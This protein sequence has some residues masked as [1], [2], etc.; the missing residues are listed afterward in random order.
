MV[1]F[2]SI[3]HSLSFYWQKSSIIMSLICQFVTRQIG[4][5][6]IMPELENGLAIFYVSFVLISTYRQNWISHLPGPGVHNTRNIQLLARYRRQFMP[7]LSSHRIPV[8]ELLQKSFD[9]YRAI[10]NV[11]FSYA[12]NDE[13]GGEL[14]LEI[15]F[16]RERSEPLWLKI[17][18]QNVHKL[19][20]CERSKLH[21]REN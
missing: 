3:L 4:S 5:T 10:K 8:L 15:R 17:E 2:Q 7:Q 18:L 14:C 16:L 20:F 21:L 11:S 12:V 13:L 6:A 19:D 9:S 1:D